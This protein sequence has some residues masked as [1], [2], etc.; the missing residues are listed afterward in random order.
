MCKGA[1]KR[2]QL[3]V[4]TLLANESLYFGVCIG[5]PATCACFVPTTLPDRRHQ[6]EEANRERGGDGEVR[7]IA[8]SCSK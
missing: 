7:K 1:L 2:A 6:F 4:I 8:N 3:S 5:K